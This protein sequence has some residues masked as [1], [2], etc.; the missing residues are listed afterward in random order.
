MRRLW[1]RATDFLSMFSAELPVLRTRLDSGHVDNTA[2]RRA[3]GGLGSMS[4]NPDC[5]EYPGGKEG[6]V[7]SK[8]LI[9]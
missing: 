1:E 8:M 6:I 5:S 3:E 9:R 7:I 4:R 2:L